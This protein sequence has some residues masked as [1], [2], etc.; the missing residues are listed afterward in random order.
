MTRKNIKIVVF[1]LLVVVVVWWIVAGL[2]SGDSAL[3]SGLESTNFLPIVFG[4]GL[5]TPAPTMNPTD[6][7]PFPPPVT[8]MP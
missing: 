6:G 5:P 8:P 2:M 1:V 3:A 7:I 4:D